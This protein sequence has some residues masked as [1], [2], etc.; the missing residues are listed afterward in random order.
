[1]EESPLPVKRLT[2][3]PVGATRLGLTPVLSGK[4]LLLDITTDSMEESPLPVKRLTQHGLK[5]PLHLP[6]GL[7]D[8]NAEAQTPSSAPAALDQSRPDR[9]HRDATQSQLTRGHETPNA[10]L[11]RKPVRSIHFSRTYT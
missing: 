8:S 7:R 3:A 5:Q 6:R 9:F 2:P 4:T 11:S 1:M 10:R